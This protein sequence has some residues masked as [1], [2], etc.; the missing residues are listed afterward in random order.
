LAF[1]FAGWCSAVFRRNLHK[2]VEDRL[3]K[4]SEWKRSRLEAKTGYLPLTNAIMKAHENVKF[5]HFSNE[6]DLLNR[7]VLGMPAKKFKELY[8]VDNVRDTCTAAQ[9]SEMER[10]QRIDSAL[11]EI[12]MPYNDRKEMLTKLHYKELALLE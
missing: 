2:W 7:I 6:A 8:E 11:V 4:E 3:K 1:E 5:Y 9:L 10:L 12:D